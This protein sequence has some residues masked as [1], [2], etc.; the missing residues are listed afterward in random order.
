[1]VHARPCRPASTSSKSIAFQPASPMFPSEHFDGGSVRLV[2]PTAI[3]SGESADALI[4]RYV[5]NYRDASENEASI[6]EPTHRQRQA[7]RGCDRTH[8]CRVDPKSAS[9]TDFSPTEARKWLVNEIDGAIAGAP[10]NLEK[11]E[12]VTFDV[13][14]DGKFKVVNTVEKLNEFKKKV[15]ASPGFREP[16]NTGPK[17]LS[18]RARPATPSATSS[19][20]A[21]T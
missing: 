10:K 12:F 15:L 21:N 2:G 1:M 13:P 3:E 9:N 6:A 19:M 11:V 8:R 17:F 16:R 5:E 7:G 4:D 20:T 18:I 14:G